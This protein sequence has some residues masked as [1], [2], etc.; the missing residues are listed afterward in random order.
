MG[1]TVERSPSQ[2]ATDVLE[3]PKSRPK[4]TGGRLSHH[5]RAPQLGR[6]SL[7][8]GETRRAGGNARSV[9]AHEASVRRYTVGADRPR[10]AIERVEELAVPAES[11][12]RGMRGCA[13]CGLGRYEGGLSILIGR[14]ALDRVARRV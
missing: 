8:R 14:E 1:N 7:T 13:V 4:R 10:A 2:T 11:H 6:R 9:D 5:S 12:I 3:V